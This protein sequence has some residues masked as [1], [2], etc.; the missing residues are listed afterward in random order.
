M[1]LIVVGRGYY[2]ITEVRFGGVGNYFGDHSPNQRKDTY[3][4]LTLI[5]AAN[6]MQAARHARKAYYYCKD[7]NKL[8][9]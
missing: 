3:N 5:Q 4:K 7:I 9:V 8:H 2:R 1:F 6:K